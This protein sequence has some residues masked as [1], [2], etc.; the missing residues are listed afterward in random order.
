MKLTLHRPII[1]TEDLNR[2]N[3]TS[4]PHETTDIPVDV[5]CYYAVD[6]YANDSRDKHK[7]RMCPDHIANIL[8]NHSMN[9]PSERI[10]A[11]AND[12]CNPR[13][14]WVGRRFTG[15]CGTCEGEAAWVRIDNTI[16]FRPDTSGMMYSHDPC[17]WIWNTPSVKIEGSSL[18]LSWSIYQ[19][20]GSFYLIVFSLGNRQLIPGQTMYNT[21]D[22]E[23]ILEMQV[24]TEYSPNP[25]LGS[26]QNAVAKTLPSLYTAIWGTRGIRVPSTMVASYQADFAGRHKTPTSLSQSKQFVANF[27]YKEERGKEAALLMKMFPSHFN[28]DPETVGWALFT[29]GLE[30]NAQ[31]A[32]NTLETNAQ[33]LLELNS[34]NRLDI[35]P[36]WSDTTPTLLQALLASGCLLAAAVLI[37]KPQLVTTPLRY[38]VSSVLSVGAYIT[39][40]GSIINVASPLGQKLLKER[41]WEYRDGF[42]LD[43]IAAPYIEERIKQRM[44]RWAPLFGISEGL[45]AIALGV[46]WQAQLPT[47]LMHTLTCYCPLP[48]AVAIHSFWNFRARVWNVVHGDVPA[49][50]ENLRAGPPPARCPGVLEAYASFRE[51]FYVRDWEERHTMDDARVGTVPFE[52]SLAATPRSVCA[53]CDPAPQCDLIKISGTWAPSEKKNPGLYFWI[54]PTSAP[55]YAPAVTDQMLMDAVR[56][57]LLAKGP[58]DPITQRTNWATLDNCPFPVYSYPPIIWDDHVSEWLEHFEPMKKKRYMPLVKRLNAGTDTWTEYAAKASRTPVF[59]KSNEVLFRRK[60][61]L[62]GD[63]CQLKPRVIINVA[64]EVQVLVG[65]VIYEVQRRLKKIWSKTPPLHEYKGFRYSIAYAGAMTDADL[66]EWLQYVLDGPTNSFWIIVSGDDSLVVFKHGHLLTCF[67]GDA[68]MYDQSESWGPLWFAHERQAQFGM[69]S[70]TIQLLR[71]LAGNKYKIETKD[72]L[73]VTFLDKRQR[74]MRDTGGSDTSLGNSMVM[75]YSWMYVV[76][77]MIDANQFDVDVVKRHFSFLGFKMKLQQLQLE[78]ATF[79]KGMWYHTTAGLYWGPLPSRVL[80][81]GKSLVDPRQI[82]RTKDFTKAS[83]QFAS[84]VC[85]SY[86]NFIR[87]PFVDAFI[88]NFMKRPLVKDFCLKY[89]VVAAD[90]PKPKLTAEGFSQI[91][92]RYDITLDDIYEATIHFPTGIF[93]QA[94]SPVYEKM[95]VVDYA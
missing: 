75:G 64:P 60:N 8:K 85:Q 62:L 82:Y 71:T 33:N 90:G 24:P 29:H 25:I 40:P 56:L 38:L 7:F 10:P 37:K 45:L 84:D 41:M 81:M 88:D 4:A 86:K 69:D 39:R 22:D 91:C 76:F 49:F 87:V 34:A 11:H 32:R 9:G 18:Y 51:R 23:T 93:Q 53:S 89:K 73:S 44:G 77:K 12:G 74:P 59:V 48:V 15:S 21:V 70:R 6:V 79:L 72:R 26:F 95:V 80:K 20:I 5:D 54:V 30:Q 36:R 94:V 16:I 66:T 57:R 17:D 63:L 28:S 52:A 43:C 1:T 47:I 46:P 19:T 58:M 27:L 42:F 50:W 67:E 83:A 78:D 55:G 3:A 31:I 35:D 13:F 2:S 65:P 61:R 68:A 14:F 92:N